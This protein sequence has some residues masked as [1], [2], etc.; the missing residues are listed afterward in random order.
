MDNGG[1]P[2]S[3]VVILVTILVLVF[4]FAGMVTFLIL[5]G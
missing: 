3:L 1:L 5:R 2:S 4:S